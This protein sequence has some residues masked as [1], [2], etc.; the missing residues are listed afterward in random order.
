MDYQSVIEYLKRHDDYT[1]LMHINPD[2]D[3]IGSAAALCSALKRY[4]KHCSVFPQEK[5]PAKFDPFIRP[6]F[7]ES[8]ASWRKAISVDV[9]LT[10]QP[11]DISADEELSYCHAILIPFFPITQPRCV[12]AEVEAIDVCKAIVIMTSVE[13]VCKGQFL[14]SVFKDK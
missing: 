10:S 1:I 9:D 8:S 14:F 5:I 11:A 7:S 6:C 4:G 2:G 3:T 12:S 13:M